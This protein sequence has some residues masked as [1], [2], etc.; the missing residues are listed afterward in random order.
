[1]FRRIATAGRDCYCWG[2]S[3]HIGLMVCMAGPDRSPG[4]GGLT[5]TAKFRTTPSRP[6]GHNPALLQQAR[7]PAAYLVAN[8]SNA[9]EQYKRSVKVL[10]L[11]LA[12]YHLSTPRSDV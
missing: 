12:Q 5:S 11:S 6:L 8:A 2:H 10:L 7:K 3:T 1:M 4:S 9:T